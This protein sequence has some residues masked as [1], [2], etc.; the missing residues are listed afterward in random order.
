MKSTFFEGYEISQEGKTFTAKKLDG[1]RYIYAKLMSEL[2]KKIRK[3]NK[4]AAEK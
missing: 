2:K 4:E 3:A 1:S